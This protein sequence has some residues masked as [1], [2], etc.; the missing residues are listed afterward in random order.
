MIDVVA[1][2]N[3]HRPMLLKAISRNTEGWT[4]ETM[5][6]AILEGRLGLFH[7]GDSVAVMQ[8]CNSPKGQYLHIL[9][10]AGK[11]EALYKLYDVVADW[12]KA[13]GCYKMTTLG[14]KGFIRRLPKMGWKQPFAFFERALT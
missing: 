6:I 14:R 4:W 1:I 8:M 3:V 2:L 12:G 7:N 13:N 10:G 9:F 11:Q 5:S